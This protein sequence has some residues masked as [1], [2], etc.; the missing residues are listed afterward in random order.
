MCGVMHEISYICEHSPHHFH[1]TNHP[2]ITSIETGED[3]SWCF[4]DQLAMELRE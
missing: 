3:W 4:I 1:A 2:I